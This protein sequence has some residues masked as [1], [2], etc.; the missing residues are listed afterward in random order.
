MTSRGGRQRTDARRVH[1]LDQRP[2]NTDGC[3][4]SRERRRHRQGIAIH[5]AG[6]CVGIRTKETVATVAQLHETT[7]RNL[8]NMRQLDECLSYLGGGSSVMRQDRGV[9]LMGRA[10]FHLT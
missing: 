9:A 4:H 10:R 7:R 5:F 2:R 8:T 1:V 3:V 6:H